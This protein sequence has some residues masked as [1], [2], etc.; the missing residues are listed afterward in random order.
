[1]P[2]SKKFPARYSPEEGGT[3]SLELPVLTVLE[4]AN[5]PIDS[6]MLFLLRLIWVWI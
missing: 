4:S 3:I 5:Q 6:T 2:D 1:M